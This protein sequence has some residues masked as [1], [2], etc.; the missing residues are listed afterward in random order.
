MCNYYFEVPYLAHN[1]EFLSIFTF[2]EPRGATASKFRQLVAAEMGVHQ[3]LLTFTTIE[4]HGFG[5]SWGDNDDVMDLP[6]E[7]LR[8]FQI[9][10]NVQDRINHG[11]YISN[12]KT[13]EKLE[14]TLPHCPNPL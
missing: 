5:R 9:P 12:Y 11:A 4:K 10:A 2:F 14:C 1:G 13:E 8:C 3:R 6:N 7:T